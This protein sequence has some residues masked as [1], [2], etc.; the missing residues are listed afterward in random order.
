[1]IVQGIPRRENYEGKYLD[2]QSII[3]LMSQPFVNYFFYIRYLKYLIIKFIFNDKYRKLH[4]ENNPFFRTVISNGKYNK[5]E[6]CLLKNNYYPGFVKYKYIS[7]KRSF[8]SIF[9]CSDLV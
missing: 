5:W 1:M 7:A 3:I 4:T 2:A 6:T 9:I 8:I